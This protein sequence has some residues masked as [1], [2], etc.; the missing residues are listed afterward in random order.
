MVRS[1][2]CPTTAQVTGRGTERASERNGMNMEGN[3]SDLIC[4]E[5]FRKTTVSIF[6]LRMGI[7]TRCPHQ[8]P[9]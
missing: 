2:G 8:I 9:L 4:L 5:G 6:C 7:I 3:N 1:S